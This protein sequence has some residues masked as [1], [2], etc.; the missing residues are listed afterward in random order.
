MF[1]QC[2]EAALK[3][4]LAIEPGHPMSGV[5]R[6]VDNDLRDDLPDRELS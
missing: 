5:S 2:S 1:E 3:L 4:L 6:N